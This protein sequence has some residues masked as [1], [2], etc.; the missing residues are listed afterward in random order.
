MLMTGRIFVDSNIWVYLFTKEDN[1]KRGIAESFIAK[2]AGENTLVISWQVVNEVSNVLKKKGFSEPDIRFVVESMTRLCIVRDYEKEIVLSA[3]A[4]R[5]NHSFSFWDSH[6]V[7]GALA[8]GCDVLASED[9]QHGR[10][11]ERLII[12]NIFA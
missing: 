5:E 1:P 7:A 9:M 10:I 6:I 11:I 3:S 12:Q 4:L 8:A 2:N